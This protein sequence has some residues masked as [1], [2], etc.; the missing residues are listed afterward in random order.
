MSKTVSKKKVSKKDKKP[1]VVKAKSFTAKKIVDSGKQIASKLAPG[2]LYV[3]STPGKLLHKEFTVE[4]VLNMLHFNLVDETYA[5]KLLGIS[6]YMGPRIN[7]RHPVS[8]KAIGKGGS[9]GLLNL[10][11]DGSALFTPKVIADTPVKNFEST[12]L[13]FTIEPVSLDIEEKPET[14]EDIP[15]EDGQRDGGET[16]ELPPEDMK[17]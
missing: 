4:E 5:C 1:F 14:D 13:V 9:I 12:G 15:A 10:Y 2:T 16:D 17:A 11:K 6:E 8:I 7:E 3:D